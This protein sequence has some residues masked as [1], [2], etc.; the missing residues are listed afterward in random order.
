M[1]CDD[2]PNTKKLFIFKGYFKECKYRNKYNS[3][4]CVCISIYEGVLNLQPYIKTIY[5]TTT[6]VVDVVL[7]KYNKYNLL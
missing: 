5:M 1:S 6:R 3:I 4:G 2:K 7:I